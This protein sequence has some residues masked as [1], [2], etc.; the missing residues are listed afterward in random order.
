MKNKKIPLLAKA[1]EDHTP[2]SF[3]EYAKKLNKPLKPEPEIKTRKK[4]SNDSNAGSIP[5]K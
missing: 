2:E 3:Y 1:F 4:K 5:N